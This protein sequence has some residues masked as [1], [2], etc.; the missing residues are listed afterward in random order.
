[1]PPG[2]IRTHDLSRRVAADLR[3]RPRGHCERHIYV[4]VYIWGL[5]FA[6]VEADL[7][8]AAGLSPE[9]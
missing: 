7:E 8:T 4:C 9:L 2:E 1:M 6:A 5:I 3:L